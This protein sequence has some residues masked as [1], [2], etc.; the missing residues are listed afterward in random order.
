MTQPR[1]R[2]PAIC[3][4]A[5]SVVPEARDSRPFVGRGYA[6]LA[7][8][9]HGRPRRPHG[10]LSR[11]PSQL[12]GRLRAG[13]PSSRGPRSPSPRR[14]SGLAAILAADERTLRRP[15][16]LGYPCSSSLHPAGSGAHVAPRA[17]APR[18]GR[19]PRSNGEAPF[20]SLPAIQQEQLLRAW[21]SDA[22]LGSR[23]GLVLGPVLK[24]AAD[25]LTGRPTARV[26]RPS[27]ATS[28]GPGGC[29]RCQPLDDAPAADTDLECDV[30]SWGR[31]RAGAV[32]G[33]EL[34]DCGLA[35]VFVEEGDH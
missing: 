24:E 11:R 14:L 10:L 16:P 7:P 8:A 9:R 2:S 26:A 31:A 35:V 20:K 1:G 34:A 23:L 32:V 18:Q 3:A 22:T 5:P 13:Q 12:P 4:G 28:N 33:S 15:A 19:H 27:S 25:F 29:R 21:Q 6:A 30:G 17:R